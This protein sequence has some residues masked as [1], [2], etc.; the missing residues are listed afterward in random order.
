MD[1]TSAQT[2]GAAE[3]AA[4]ENIGR[5]ERVLSMVTGAWML[6]RGLLRARHSPWSLAV[7]L[8]GLPMIRRGAT[9][10]S[11][12]YQA[13]GID[14]ERRLSLTAGVDPRRA[15]TAEASVMVERPIGE[16]YEFWRRFENLPQFFAEI[17][18]VSR[19][20]GGGWR[21]VAAG[22]L[23]RTLEWEVDVT[24]DVELQRIVWRSRP[25]SVVASE[26]VVEFHAV[27]GGTEVFVRLMFEPLAGR[28]GAQVA[29]AF[30]VDA[31]RTLVRD[32]SRMRQILEARAEMLPAA[33]STY[34]VTPGFAG[35]FTGEFTGGD[36]DADTPL[37]R[38]RQEIVDER[39]ASI[40]DRADFESDQSFPA[41]DAPSRY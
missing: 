20:E 32:L 37:A 14:T 34:D 7:A 36:D 41:S 22:P 33:A 12:L 15:E 11:K 35:D 19:I 27:P 5:G 38:A 8:A 24:Q 23:G 1:A 2:Q 26:G 29:R 30:G 4:A 3:D 17:D 21:W 9:G 28:L 13:L 40:R 18:R 31:Q 16:V 39:D 10:R 6:A 25:G